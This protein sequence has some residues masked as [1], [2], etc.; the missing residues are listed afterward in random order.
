MCFASTP[1]SP[2]PAPPPPPPPPAP[3]L[4]DKNVQVAGDD[5]R[6]RAAAAAGAMS[7]IINIGGAGGLTQPA[8]TTASA[9][10]DKL[11]G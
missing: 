11:G 5:A 1:N 9:G 3:Q 10:K 7:T 4:P 8:S 6:K 2:A